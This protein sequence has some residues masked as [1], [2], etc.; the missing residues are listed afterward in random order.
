MGSFES[1]AEKVARDVL[2]LEI[3][4][5]LRKDI[6]DTAK[7]A[8]RA[9][10]SSDGTCSRCKKNTKF[11]NFCERCGATFLTPEM[12]EKGEVN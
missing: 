9:E 6:L 1:G 3:S 12:I 8:E 5:E 10:L 7:A 2:G 4:D 11:G